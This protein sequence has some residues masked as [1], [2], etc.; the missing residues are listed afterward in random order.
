MMDLV[1][2]PASH[3]HTPQRTAG[4]RLTY[5]L[6]GAV[7]GAGLGTFV[8]L[9]AGLIV[10]HLGAI[11]TVA[12]V[13]AVIGAA[14]GSAVSVRVVGDD[15]RITNPFRRYRV[16]ADRVAKI[17]SVPGSNLRLGASLGLL[18]K[19]GY[20]E[21]PVRALRFPRPGETIDPRSRRAAAFGDVARWARRNEIPFRT[22]AENWNAL[23]RDQVSEPVE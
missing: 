10:T 15:L 23:L 17:V 4:L 19:Q 5:T 9:C 3:R 6:A 1:D 18:M 7:C 20:Q 14:R 8:A 22:S 21:I 11:P 13:G 16:S 2:E 12:A